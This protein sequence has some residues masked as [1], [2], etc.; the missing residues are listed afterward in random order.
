MTLQSPQDNDEAL[1]AF[2]KANNPIPWI[3]STVDVVL[4]ETLKRRKAQ[5]DPG[6][7]GVMTALEDNVCLNMAE[8]FTQLSTEV[9]AEWSLTQP[10]FKDEKREKPLSSVYHRGP[11]GAEMSKDAE[12]LLKGKASKLFPGKPHQQALFIAMAKVA[13]A[14]HD[15][16]QAKGAPGNE[17]DS[18][19]LFV[20]KCNQVFKEFGLSDDTNLKRVMDDFGWETIVVGTTFD[21]T[22]KRPVVDILNEASVRFGESAPKQPDPAIACATFA[23]GKN[24]TRRMEVTLSQYTEDDELKT[25]ITQQLQSTG[26]ENNLFMQFLTQQEGEK[27]EID[28]TR[29]MAARHMIGQNCRMICEL[30]THFG[31]P[32]AK[33]FAE[34][35]TKLIFEAAKKFNS[36]QHQ[37]LNQIFEGVN[38]DRY[39]ELLMD[40]FGGDKGEI[41][42]AEGLTSDSFDE[43][44]QNFN[45]LYEGLEFD[46][47]GNGGLWQQYAQDVRKFM[48]HIKTKLVELEGQP[49]KQREFKINLMRDLALYGGHQMGSALMRQDP[50]L[51]KAYEKVIQAQEAKLKDKGY[52]DVPQDVEQLK[53]YIQNLQNPK[54]TQE[55]PAPLTSVDQNVSRPPPLTMQRKHEES[56]PV[57]EQIT[58]CEALLQAKVDL[59]RL[60]EQKLNLD[61]SKGVDK[62]KAVENQ[63]TKRQ[64]L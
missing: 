19:K 59:Q 46:L 15:A 26:G 40:S 10:P 53:L 16:I 25:L 64:K 32:E 27:V 54:P 63:E 61:L 12:L 50:Q 44:V 55:K 20:E 57:T 24:D 17:M 13:H 3:P 47:K 21:I 28:S 56:K 38:I 2:L 36:E 41:S 1:E 29:A 39:F 42:F 11:H 7:T 9:I 58:M 37:D 30:K 45:K 23:T 60:K 33:Q 52:N 8:R 35:L 4:K 22:K 34:F 18:Y 43:A 62:G 31:N 48:E 5:Q 49:D 6:F 14:I 51:E